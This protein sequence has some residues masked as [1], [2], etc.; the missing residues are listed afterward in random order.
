MYIEKQMTAGEGRSF[1]IVL[2]EEHAADNGDSLQDVAKSV[3]NR[4]FQHCHHLPSL[5]TGG[6]PTKQARADYIKI[7]PARQGLTNARKFSKICAIKE[8]S[9]WS[10]ALQVMNI[11][12]KKPRNFY[13]YGFLLTLFQVSKQREDETACGQSKAENF[14][15]RHSRHPLLRGK[16]NNRLRADYIK[17]FQF[18]QGLTNARKFSKIPAENKE[19]SLTASF[20]KIKLIAKAAVTLRLFNYLKKT[21]KMRAAVPSACKIKLNFSYLVML[22]TSPFE[23]PSLADLR[24]LYKNFSGASRR[25]FFAGKNFI[26]RTTWEIFFQSKKRRF[27][28]VI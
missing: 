27:L 13:L 25:F 26:Q 14:I 21:S 17:I 7:F 24:G 12:E 15:F 6:K 18:R 2:L 3:N 8:Q 23:E 5:R 16:P 11:V 20:D 4:R 1:Y 10:P 22:I 28:N 9:V 19:V